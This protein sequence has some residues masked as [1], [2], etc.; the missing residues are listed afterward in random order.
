LGRVPLVDEDHRELERRT[1][2]GRPTQRCGRLRAKVP[3]AVERKAH[4]KLRHSP[5]DGN[6]AKSLAV[7]RSR[8]TTHQRREPAR[9]SGF[10]KNRKSDSTFAQVDA[11]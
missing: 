7:G 9:C 8:G 4:H 11:E 6:R 5:F 2:F 1:N 10:F 3:I